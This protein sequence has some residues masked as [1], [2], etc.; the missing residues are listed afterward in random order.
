MLYET[1]N[2]LNGAVATKLLVAETLADQ[3]LTRMMNVSRVVPGEWEADCLFKNF[4]RMIEDAEFSEEAPSA[5]VRN[6]HALENLLQDAH[7]ATYALQLAQAQLQ[8][9]RLQGSVDRSFGSLCSKL[10][11]MVCSQDGVIRRMSAQW[12]TLRQEG[13]LLGVPNLTRRQLAEARRAVESD[14]DSISNE[15]ENEYYAAL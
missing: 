14:E 12:E 13:A 4:Q 1:L 8:A 9:L 11:L 10:E 5:L 6:G 3:I 7:A 2:E 15:V